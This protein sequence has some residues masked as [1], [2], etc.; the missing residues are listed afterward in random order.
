M[1]NYCLK[2]TTIK[3]DDTHLNSGIKMVKKDDIGIKLR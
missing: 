1:Y 3:K 2:I